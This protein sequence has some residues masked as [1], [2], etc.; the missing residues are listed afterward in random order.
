MRTKILAALSALA[1]ALGMVAFTATA[2]DATHPTVK[3]TAT[4]NP[5]TGMSDI[6]WT[7]G[8]D[9]NY[10]NETATIAYQSAAT[11]PTLI[12]QS[13]KKSGTVSAVQSGLSAGTYSFT[14]KVQWTNHATGD[15][16]TKSSEPV[17][18][19]G[20]CQI[21]DATA[22]V[23]TSG[24]TCDTAQT[25]ILNTPK[26]ATWNKNQPVLGV[27]GQGRTTF[28]ATATANDHHTFADGKASFTTTG[29]LLPASG[30]C[31]SG[32]AVAIY[33]YPLVDSSK[34]A[35]WE[36]S[37]KQTFIASRLASS[38]SDWYTA[39][40]ALP[41]EVCGTGW[42]VQQDIA[43][44]S[45]KFALGDFPAIV[46]RSSNT[47]VLG[48]P[49][50]VAAIHQPLSALV[51]SI[52]ACGTLVVPVIPT[53]ATSAETCSPTSGQTTTTPGTVTFP[54]GD[55]TWKDANNKAV[56]GTVS[57]A[58]GSYTF[59]VTANSGFKF[60]AQGSTTMQ[61]TVEVGLKTLTG[62]CLI[63][64]TPV[65]PGV[66]A[67]DVCGTANDT[68]TVD[69]T[70]D[71]VAYTVTWNANRSAATV[72][73]SVTDATKYVFAAGATTSWTYQFST[74]PCVVAV[75]IA[76][77][78]SAQQCLP[79]EAGIA[80][81]AANFTQES[82]GI[83]VVLDKNLEYTITGA[84]TPPAYGPAVATSAF[85]QLAPGDYTVTVKAL[86]GY[87]LPTDAVF[88]WPLTVAPGICGI[89]F[90]DPYPMP[91]TC[92]AFEEGATQPGYIWV[93]LS[94]NLANELSYR[95][96]G[97]GQD[98]TATQEINNL[99]P[100]DYSV[101]ATAKPGFKLDTEQS[102][103]P[104]LTITP[105]GTC[106]LVT[107]P[108][109]S[110][111][112]TSTNI[113]CASSG[114]Y[115]LANT[116]GIV[117]YEYVNGVKTLTKAGTYKVTDASTVKIHAELLDSTFGWEDNAQKDWTF[118]FTSPVNCLPTLAFT[119]STGGN[120]GLLLAGGFLLV[121]GVIIAFERRL[122]PRTK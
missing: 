85:T 98:F 43:Q 20:A 84:G 3:G 54:I 78:A 122:R 103:W 29:T 108:L 76:P 36:N 35:S 81:A 90:A 4:C 111:T 9:V 117:W 104:K 69:T 109:I 48:W 105:A 83:N 77:T 80:M 33:V 15:L 62:P 70:Q 106:T 121:G 86:N 68:L 52:P 97:N 101:T 75:S 65:K 96:V 94:G 102:V 12:G 60:D 59:T 24:P 119:G 26:N 61:F 40:P 17:T 88:S 47:G 18:V 7:V 37:G 39:L 115:T 89:T 11:T 74:E 73:A 28:S 41:A 120:A 87:V 57:Y 22:T 32:L 110:T 51:T 95:I 91:Q 21:A 1:L 14:V 118:T 5:S 112:A 55:W 49:P 93:D 38:A 42:G 8:G 82:G 23:S 58:A 79:A 13:V 116:T 19:S 71:H 63:E 45:N 107:H 16:V 31:V 27:D 99:P 34:P 2:A 30:N 25:L 72:E 113:T 66:T 67:T 6:T 10:P 100:G 46:E 64:V 44:L 114:T 56:S 53:V 92:S 50:I